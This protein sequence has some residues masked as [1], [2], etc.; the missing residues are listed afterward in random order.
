MK[1]EEIKNLKDEYPDSEVL[2][3]PECACGSQAM[4]MA[5]R[6]NDKSIHFLSTEAMIGKSQESKSKNVIVATEEGIIH[7]MKKACPEKNFIPIN[8]TSK[9]NFM[10]M[11]TVEK[12]YNSL[13]TES[14]EIKVPIE[15]ALKAKTAIDRMIEIG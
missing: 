11:I 5:E 3:H 12:I 9:C 10:K 6:N 7:K 4:L 13:K 8:R 15:L 1:F 2:I 14:P